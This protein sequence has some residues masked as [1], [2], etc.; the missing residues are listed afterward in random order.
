MVVNLDGLTTPYFIIYQDKLDKN[1]EDYKTALI[2]EWPNSQLSFSVKTNSLPWLLEYIRDKGIFA[3][4]VSKEE[5]LLAKRCGYK[6]NE[7]IFNGPI[8]N[9]DIFLDSLTMGATVNIDSKEEL[10]FLFGLNEQ[11]R[12]NIGIRINPNPD[13]FEEKDIAYKNDGFRFG[14]SEE[15]GELNRAISIVRGASDFVGLH[16]HCNSITRSKEVYIALANYAKKIIKKYDLKVS[17]IDIGGGFFGGIPGKTTAREYISVIKN[18][19]S[20]VVDINVTKLIIE[21]GSAI[22][23]SCVDLVT[24]VI[25]V[26]ETCRSRIVTTDGS[27]IHI[28]P[29][30]AKKS[31]VYTLE[32]KSDSNIT[33]QIICGYTCMDHDRLMTIY[34]DKKLECGDKIIYHRVGAYSVTFGG[35]FIS[36]YPDVY[37]KKSENIEKVRGK[38]SVDDFYNIHSL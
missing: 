36:Y 24:K 38:I 1:I 4:V 13:I 32:N 2:N 28:D 8:K 14:F 5:Y 20:K 6:D 31:Y 22:I 27:R 15:T 21:P 30:W 35:M 9:K 18:V 7:I 11:N 19:L 29:L 37:I 16:I 23:G 34:N 33:K 25:D 26:K 17:Y 3:E 10:N 12:N